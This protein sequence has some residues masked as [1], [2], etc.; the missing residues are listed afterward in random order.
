MHFLASVMVVAVLSGWVAAPVAPAAGEAPLSLAACLREALAAN[1]DLAAADAR[2]RAAEAGAE[3]EAAARRPRLALGAGYLYS[4]RAQRLLQPSFPG[5]VI[6]FE[7]DV[8]DATLEARLP[9]YTGGVLAARRQAAVLAASESGLARDALEADLALAVTGAYLTAVAQRADVRALEGSLAALAAQVALARDLEEVGRIPALDRIKVE[10]RDA[11]VRQA[12]SAARRDRVLVLEHL[13]V[14]LG[15]PPG[16]PAPEVT[17]APPPIEPG[18][19]PTELAARAAATRP[20]L[21]ALRDGVA[22]AQ[23]ELAAVRG[24]RRPAVEAY[25]RYTTRAAVPADAEATLPGHEEWASAG[26]DFRIALWNGGAVAARIRQ[27]EAR[28]VEAEARLRGAE[29]RVV[30]EVRRQAASLAEA[31]EREAVAARAVEQA[32]EAYAIERAA[33]E[34]GRGVVNDV[35]DAEAARLEAELA[36]TRARHDRALAAV[37]LARAAG[38]DLVALMGAR[39]EEPR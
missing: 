39:M 2:V 14:L 11:S 4:D 7:D 16:E 10:V 34:L 29:F 26:I 35:L 20:E 6:R 13:A 22:R 25:A 19:T 18:G 5:E 8:A 21:A 1:F 23:A 3:A 15:R 9:L 33:Y 36:L 31:T 28:R 24:G 17:E 37:A 30:E 27:A 38:M 32:R 12:L